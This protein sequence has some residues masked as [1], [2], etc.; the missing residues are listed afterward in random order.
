[1]RRRFRGHTEQLRIIIGKA[2][3]AK[4]KFYE[5][6]RTRCHRLRPPLVSFV[7]SC[8]HLAVP[9]A[10]QNGLKMGMQ[11]HY[12]ALIIVYWKVK[13]IYGTYFLSLKRSRYHER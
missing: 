2:S 9:T 8:L 3:L 7:D 4:I 1:M 12:L 13:L 5:N 6:A 11:G 10:I